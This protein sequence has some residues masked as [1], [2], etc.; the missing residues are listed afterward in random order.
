MKAHVDPLVCNAQVVYTSHSPIKEAY[1]AHWLLT[2]SK[3]YFILVKGAF[4]R[5]LC[6]LFH[7]AVYLKGQL[8]TDPL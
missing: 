4:S 3:E 6:V 5:H 2:V 7:K 1:A 8:H